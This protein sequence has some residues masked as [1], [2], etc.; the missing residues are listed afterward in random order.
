W[1]HDV[2]VPV[3]KVADFLV[4]ATGA[5]ERFHPG[6]RVVA[7]GHV[8]DGNVHF[9]VVQPIGA[10]HDAFSA[11]RDEGARIVHDI[12]ARFDGS[13]SAEQGRGS[14]KSAEALRYKSPVQ[15]QAMRAVREALDPLRIMN[16]R[17]LF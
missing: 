11:R 8:G 2:S 17:V 5:I 4:E 1:K 12:V 13:I 6:A 7:F 15:V 16:P 14:M 10:D 3:S 9:D